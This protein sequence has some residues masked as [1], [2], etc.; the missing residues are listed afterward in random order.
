MN[1]T[2]IEWTDY[3][4]NPVTGCTKVSQGCKHCYAETLYKRFGKTFGHEFTHVTLHPERLN[5]PLLMSKKLHGKKVFVCDMSDLFHVDVP[6]QFIDE[7]FNQFRTCPNTTF[8]VLTKR[9]L[10][11]HNFIRSRIRHGHFVQANVILGA[12]CED[13]STFNERSV[14]IALLHYAGWKTFL[15]LEPLL[16]PIELFMDGLHE[17]SFDWIIAGGESGHGARPMHP[18]WVRSLRDQCASANVPFFFKQWGAWWPGHPDWDEGFKRHTWPDGTVSF[19]MNKTIA[20]NTLDG[21]Q[22]LE[23]PTTQLLTT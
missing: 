21:R 13:Q 3:T 18:D 17:F 8:Q 14:A 6:D 20:G 2:T 23:F 9:T 4:W 7:V 1:K 16:G 11:M 15:S 19:R 10:R 22:H 5:E 12:S